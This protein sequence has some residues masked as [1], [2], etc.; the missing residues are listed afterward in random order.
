M[1]THLM[2]GAEIVKA[3]RAHAATTIL[4]ADSSKYGETGFISVLP[5]SDMNLII[6]DGG[7]ND[8]AAAALAGAGVTLR[9]V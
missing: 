5:L 1:T 9:R 4:T 6:T 8:E 7:L 2:E 3:M